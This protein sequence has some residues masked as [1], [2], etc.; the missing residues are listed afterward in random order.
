MHGQ[1]AYLHV[2]AALV[3]LLSGL[4]VVFWRKGKALHRLIG[5]AYVFAMLLTNVSAL[6]IYHLTGHFGLFHVFALLSLFYT[7]AGLAMPLLRMRNW[8]NAHVQWMTWSYLSLLAA[9][10]N[11]LAVRL[12]LHVNT[13]PRIFAVGAILGV[14]VLI[15]RLAL[16]PKLKSMVL[17]T[18]VVT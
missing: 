2:A 14:S 10:L 15:A 12:P 17:K 9:S 1:L 8:L 13:P 3:A 16:R 11:E 7:L 4:F 18:G 6:M 5:I